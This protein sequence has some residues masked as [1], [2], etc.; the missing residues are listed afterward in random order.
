M[1]ILLHATRHDHGRPYSVEM[2]CMEGIVTVL[3]L[4]CS[5]IVNL[6]FT[7]NATMPCII[8]SDYVCMHAIECCVLHSLECIIKTCTVSAHDNEIYTCNWR[9]NYIILLGVTCVMVCSMYS[10]WGDPK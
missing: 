1:I 8:N 5:I 4:P 2:L 3:L 9:Y 10:I 6:Y 7:G